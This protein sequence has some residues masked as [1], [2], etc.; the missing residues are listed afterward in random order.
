MSNLVIRQMSQEDLPDADRINRVAFGTFFGLETPSAFRGDGDVVAG[1]FAAN[2]EGAF[3]AEMD[4]LQVACGFVMDWCSV[5]ILGPLTVDVDAWG[6]GIGR[7]MLDEMA[8]YMDSH[9]F[10]L[11]GLFTH[12]QSATHIR[13]YE[14]YGFR[15][16]R[17]T[18]VMDRTV[19]PE[20]EM[21]P[22]ARLF[23]ELAVSERPAVLDACRSI[24]GSVYRG[25]DLTG[26]ILS[27]DRAGFGDTVLLGPDTAMT[28]F[29]CCHQGSGSE[30]GSPQ[31]LVKF[32]AVRP[33]ENGPAEFEALMTA[34]EVFAAAR[35]TERLVAG[36][37]TGR[38][39]C[40]E[41]MLDMGFRTW[42]NGIA[43]L[44]T[45]GDARGDGY[46]V[47][48]IYAIDDWR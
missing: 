28:G 22:T 10:A 25:L 41:A 35:E 12:P 14:A 30:A 34:C 38:A 48:G 40:Y 43:M 24:A 16:K 4:G 15:M 8:G 47:P 19:R 3:V 42:M 44:K 17:I 31:T 11:Q 37:N 1:R 20:T 21:P 46:N 18:A 33:A 26:E 27:I 6:R 32:A 2:P 9:G 36:T 5:G 45:A 39:E 13:L 23:S 29:A 7:A